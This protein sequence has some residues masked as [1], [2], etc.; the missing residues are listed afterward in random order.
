[1][2][3]VVDVFIASPSDVRKERK[4]VEEAVQK[5]SPRTRDSLGIVL[6][7]VSWTNFLPLAVKSNKDRVQ[8]RFSQR[9]R[10]CHIFVGILYQRYGEEIDN[11]RRISGTEEEFD[12]AIKYRN[13]IELLTYFRDL[14]PNINADSGLV[15]QVAKLRKLKQRLHSDGLLSKSYSG[16]EEYREM[17]TL[18]LFE[19]V[20]RISNEIERR[21]QY[22]KFFRFGIARKQ[23]A[24]SVL[25]GYPALQDYPSEKY[26]N[27]PFSSTN[28]KNSTQTGRRGI[29]WQERLLPTVIY[30]DFKCIQK[31][32]SAVNSSGVSD[33]SSVTTDHPRLHGPGN[34]IWLCIPRNSPAQKQLRHLGKRSWF[35]FIT[36]QSA[37]RPHISWKSNKSEPVIVKSPL[38]RYL[39]RQRTESNGQWD[40]KHGEIVARDYA[41]IGRFS[42]PN[43]PAITQSDPYFHYYLAGIRGLGTWGV[44]WYID[45]RPDELVRLLNEQQVQGDDVQVLLEVTLANNRI[46]AVNDV[47]NKGQD[48]FNKQMTKKVILDTIDRNL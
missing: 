19:A 30:E 29:N 32:E 20:I 47:S 11:Q 14:P 31:I 48:Y 40:P 10:K 44:G 8:D 17:I 36:K 42:E 13:R 39:K 27:T 21:E 24:P 9:V 43:S 25:L 41:V 16:P 2:D 18:D 38:S 12:A 22:Q 37:S 46:V 26:V 1:M 35:Q 23:H 5:I 15:E 28:K 4:Y 7:P 6:N 33:I 45:R 34:R 3:Q